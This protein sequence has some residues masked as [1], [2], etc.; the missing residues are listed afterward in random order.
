MILEN[1]AQTLRICFFLITFPPLIT[2][3]P[4]LSQQKKKLQK[5][6]FS[7]LVFIAIRYNILCMV[8]KRDAFLYYLPLEGHF[9]RSILQ[10]LTKRRS[11]KPFVSLDI[12]LPSSP[13][14]TS[15]LHRKS[16]TIFYET[17]DKSFLLWKKEGFRVKTQRGSQ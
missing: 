8:P 13:F 9:A 1:S 7:L 6:T 11:P 2:M 16:K 3:A 5:C 4:L 10:A 14:P 15:A 12:T 17:W